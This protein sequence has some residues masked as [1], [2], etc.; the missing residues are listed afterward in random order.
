MTA[1]NALKT[2]QGEEVE[3]AAALAELQA[4]P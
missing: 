4:K 1:E 2:A 3:L